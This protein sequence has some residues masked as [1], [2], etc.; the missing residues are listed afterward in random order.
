[1]GNASIAYSASDLGA[2]IALQTDGV[3]T[4]TALLTG[5]TVKQAGA[6]GLYV[7]A[8]SSTTSNL[9]VTA[10]GN[11]FEVETVDAN[12]FL[13]VALIT[14]GSGGSDTLCAHFSGNVKELGNASGGGAGIATE[15]GG[16]SKMELQ[17]YSSGSVATF[18]NGTATTVSPA[19]QD[20]GGGG[21]VIGATSC[22]TPP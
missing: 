21:T 5:N 8:T 22:A 9:N 1:V 2:G 10:S 19:A 4:L 16:S 13:G 7:D 3:G 15:E 12:S 17:G 11:D 14:G 18:L 20:F 6:D